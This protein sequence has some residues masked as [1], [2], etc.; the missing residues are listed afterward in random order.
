MKRRK[1]R[2][3]NTSLRGEQYSIRLRMKAL[4]VCS[5]E[6]TCAKEGFC[7]ME[8]AQL[9]TGFV[10]QVVNVAFPYKIMADS[11]MQKHS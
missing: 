6:L 11:E 9:A 7:N 5:Q 4:I 3:E 10:G 1:V 8:N 2:G